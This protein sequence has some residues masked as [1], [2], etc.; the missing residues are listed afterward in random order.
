MNTGFFPQEFFQ[1]YTVLETEL[2]ISLY[3]QCFETQW[4][5]VFAQI[6]EDERVSVM[7]P[8]S[9]QVEPREY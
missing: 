7:T 2:L 5:I 9:S 1:L 4:K 3:P 6:D 8:S